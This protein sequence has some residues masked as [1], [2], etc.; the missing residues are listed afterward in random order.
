MDHMEQKKNCTAIVLAAGSGKRMGGAVAKQYM[1]L[2]GKPVLYYALRAIEDSAIVDSCILVVGADEISYV[3][4]EVVERFDFQK[5]S[6]VIAGGSER[7]HSVKNALSYLLNCKTEVYGTGTDESGMCGA[8]H[9]DIKAEVGQ[10]EYVMIHDGARPFLTETLLE[11]LYKEV[12][13]YD[14][15]C[16]AVPVKDTIKIADEESFVVETPKRS[17]LYAIQTPQAFSLNTI[18][19][20]YSM[21]E[22]RE[23]ELREQGILI[24]DDAMVVEHMLH[25]KVKLVPGSYENIK[26]TTP[27][28]MEVAKMF[29]HQA[30]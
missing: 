1:D 23:A 7:Y 6:A 29:L 21:L 9:R 13:I 4:E 12:M 5:I 24:T 30:P 18:W 11:N 16:A 15:V 14:S 3:K 25:K 10:K 28:D 27:E 19:S 8:G 17:S 2:A 26:I 22:E 20:A